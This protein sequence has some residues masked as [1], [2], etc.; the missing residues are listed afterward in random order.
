MLLRL[1][2]NWYL[3]DLVSKKDTLRKNPTLGV[4]GI[5]ITMQ[6]PVIPFCSGTK[7]L[8][9]YLIFFVLISFNLQAQV[10][11]NDIEE[12]E[13]IDVSFLKENDS[14]NGGSIH[15][16]VLRIKNMKNQPVTIGVN[17]S[18]PQ[19]WPLIAN[20]SQQ[21]ELEAGAETYL[22]VR[23]SVPTDVVGGISYIFSGVVRFKEEFFYASSYIF[24]TSKSRWNMFVDRNTLY[25]NEFKTQEHFEIRLSNTGNRE[26]LIRL[27]FDVGKMLTIAEVGK[28]DSIRY[29]SVPAYTDTT[30]V[31]TVGVN[32]GISYAEKETSKNN[33]KEYNVLLKA[34]TPDHAVSTSV[35]VQQLQSCETS[36]R[37][38]Q[39]SPLNFDLML[40]NL[41]SSQALK[42]NNKLYGT[43][44]FKKNRSL[45]YALNVNN[46]YFDL[47]KNHGFS[48]AEN[49]R[50]LMG[51]YGDNLSVRAGDNI[52]AG[53]IHSING[54]GIDVHIKIMEKNNF[55][56]TAVQNPLTY[57]R[58]INL[59]FTRSLGPVSSTLGFIYD[60]NPRTK[61]YT[62]YSLAPG[63]GFRF[64]KFNTF[65]AQFVLSAVK[66]GNLLIAPGDTSLRGFG[67]RLY[68]RYN[69]KKFRLQFSNLN[70]N[71]DY[72]RN[73]GINRFNLDANYIIK[74]EMLL[75]S[76]FE[77]N[78][79]NATKYPYNFYN[80]PNTNRNDHGR[81]LFSYNKKKTVYQGGPQYMASQRLYNDSYSGFYTKYTDYSPGIYGALTY[82]MSSLKS[83]TPN[84]SMNNLNFRFS[85][86]DTLFEDY[87]IHNKWFYSFGLNYYDYTWRVNL[88][89][90]SGST[91][92]LYKSVLTEE[93]PTVSQAFHIRPSYE[94]YLKD[95]T[96]RLSGYVNYSY[97]MPSGR[98]NMVLNLSADYFLAKRWQLFFSFNM[99][100]VA[101]VDEDLGRI[102]SRN[103]NT[104][105]GLRKSFDIQQP[106][107]KFY[108]IKIYC[109]NDLNGNNIR[110]DQE[111]PISNI[112]VI[113]TRNNSDSLYAKVS[114]PQTELLTDADGQICYKNMPEGVYVAELS[115]LFNLENM[116][117]LDGNRQLLII[118]DDKTIYLPLVESFKVSGQIFV[119]RDPN[120]TE[121]KITLEGIKISALSEDGYSYSTL[122][123]KFGYYILNLPHDKTYKIMM[124][125]VFNENFNI[126]Q[127]EY[128][129]RFGKSRSIK[130]DF[131]VHEKRREINFDENKNFYQFKN[132]NP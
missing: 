21:I 109:F 35:R 23:L 37:N 53:M 3:P 130:I 58:G 6:T 75:Y 87:S 17:F 94:R 97:Y 14:V 10:S 5:D 124:S 12:K 83:I 98:E 20:F 131:R 116:F 115:P 57:S 64:L 32:S 111:K 1:K 76:Y 18:A 103:F 7:S 38:T 25:L 68:Y 99:F 11:T 44:L 22:P 72:L 120:S 100:N 102:S 71:F 112:L 85:T 40:Y 54:R 82:R 125:N 101:R 8:L 123:D 19:D 121:G 59:M 39:V 74:P 67:Y 110:D 105:V 9:S 43:I 28:G 30:L 132:T 119:E 56:V 93:E 70:T 80:P 36:V 51:Y 69:S 96:I 104:I 129:I 34:S 79:Y 118:D 15:F 27:T 26:E 78:D 113:I 108:D 13:Q 60:D 42:M 106:R 33:W 61:S 107:L 122:T 66:Y 73:S 91:S 50:F 62:A 126:E 92:D 16:N 63:I 45:G 128:T 52:G 81:I 95:N 31:Y 117:F 49:V 90:T 89:Y 84:V 46:L 65:N 55:S 86:N 41:M 77:R 4:F 2:L 114:F 88:Y 48:V 29:V 127:Q 47:T 24:V